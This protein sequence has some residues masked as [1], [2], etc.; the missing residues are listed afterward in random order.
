MLTWYKWYGLKVKEDLR[1]LDQEEVTSSFL[2]DV[3]AMSLFV[4]QFVLLKLRSC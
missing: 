3:K 1:G 2:P 4:Q